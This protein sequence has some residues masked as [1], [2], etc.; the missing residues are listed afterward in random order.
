MLNSLMKPS[1][2]LDAEKLKSMNAVPLELLRSPLG[3]PYTIAVF[4]YHHFKNTDKV[5]WPYIKKYM[6]HKKSYCDSSGMEEFRYIILSML[7][8]NQGR[9]VLTGSPSYQVFADFLNDAYS[10]W[11]GRKI[12]S[13]KEAV[14]HGFCYY[15][16]LTYWI[17]LHLIFFLNI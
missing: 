14:K 11:E 9:Q 5:W 1:S 12:R 15:V 4:N 3:S 8:F 10:F 17:Q 6:Y 16:P 7:H 2:C 13:R